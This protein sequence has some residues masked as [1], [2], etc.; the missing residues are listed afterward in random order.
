MKELFKGPVEV[1]TPCFC[2]GADQSK[3]EIRAPSIRG[4]LRWWF[5][6]LGG[7]RE[8]EGSLFGSVDPARASKV[9]VRVTDLKLKNNK[10]LKSVTTKQQFFISDRPKLN[11]DTV[12]IGD[13]STFTLQILLKSS[14]SSESLL[15]LA[16]RCFLTFGSLG[17]RSNRGLGAIQK[18]AL[19]KNEFEDLVVELSRRNIDI[20]SFE[21]ETT[22]YGALAQLEA[23]IKGFRKEQKI[24]KNTANAMGFVQ[25]NK[26]HASCLRVRPVKI[27]QYQFIPVMRYSESHLGAGIKSLRSELKLHLEKVN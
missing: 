25:G 13:G 10:G 16:V 11:Q 26:R 2:V 12:M 3:A 5:R 27:A 17:L 6:A 4:E 24:E 18:I 7:T 15:N 1:I 14:D 9:I 19:S 23:N 8:Q 20:Y 21:P 22:A